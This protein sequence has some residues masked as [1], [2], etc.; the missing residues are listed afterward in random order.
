MNYRRVTQFPATLSG[1]ADAISASTVGIS[2]AISE[3]LPAS[4][5]AVR[6]A[7]RPVPEEQQLHLV[8]PCRISIEARNPEVAGFSIASV[9]R[10]P[11]E[12][13]L[14]L[15][16]IARIEALGEPA[17]DRSEK[18]TRFIPLALIAP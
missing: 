9:R 10:Q 8:V 2:D 3:A 16:Q 6:N 12:Q 11:I 13:R 7:R 14:G 18:I 5:S 15:L 1:I 4:R 17:I